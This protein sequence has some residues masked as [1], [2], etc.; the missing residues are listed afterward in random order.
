VK[1]LTTK[2]SIDKVNLRL[3][4]DADMHLPAYDNTKLVAINTCPTWGILRYSMHK[5]MSAPGVTRAMALEMGSA[6]HEVFA[7]VRLWQ[8][9]P[10]PT[11]KA[12]P[13]RLSWTKIVWRYTLSS[14]A[15]QVLTTR[16]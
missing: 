11:K 7:A 9:A 3:T 13:C 4:T 15:L 5:T 2:L 10:L 1:S 12:R 6:A 14:Y 8:I 16:R